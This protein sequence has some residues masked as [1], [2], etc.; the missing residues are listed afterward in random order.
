MS[1]AVMMGRIAEA[2]PRAG[3][4]VG[5]LLL[6]HL[7]AGLIVPFIL[8]ERATGRSDRQSA[9]PAVIRT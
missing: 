7:A 2:S 4:S 3:R 6:V 9:R 1:T 5:M 8:L